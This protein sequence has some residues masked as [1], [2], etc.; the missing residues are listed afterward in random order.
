[1]LGAP[2]QGVSFSE[3]ATLL[4]YGFAEFQESDLAVPGE[5]E[6]TVLLQG[7]PVLVTATES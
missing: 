7:E 3:A 6:G 4:N 1:M 2:T 5:T